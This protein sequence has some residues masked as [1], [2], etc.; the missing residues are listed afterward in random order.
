MHSSKARSLEADLLCRTCG[1]QTSKLAP[2]LA[3]SDGP[4]LCLQK[5]VAHLL[6]HIKCS[7]PRKG[8]FAELLLSNKHHKTGACSLISTH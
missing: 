8:S 4:T 1:N 3:S 7:D 2:E 6:S 5:Q